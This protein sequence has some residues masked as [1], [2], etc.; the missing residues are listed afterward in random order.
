MRLPIQAQAIT[1]TKTSAGIGLNPSANN[2][3]EGK[4]VCRKGN[5]VLDTYSA[6]VCGPNQHDTC[7][8]AKVK[9]VNN[10]AQACRDLGGTITQST[11]RCTVGGKCKSVSDC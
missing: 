6:T 1:I 8:E 4:A 2:C 11:A 7:T 5:S 10:N 3:V 9:A